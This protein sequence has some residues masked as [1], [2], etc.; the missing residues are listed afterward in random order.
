MSQ[1]APSEVQP[2]HVAPPPTTSPERRWTLIAVLAVVACA[3]V[4]LAVAWTARHP[5]FPFDEVST[6]QMSRMLAGD[7]TP[8][9]R[10]AGYFPGWALVLAPIWWFVSDPETFYRIGAVV[11]VAVSLL[12]IWPLALLGR[13]L[14]LTTAQ[15]VAAAAIVMAM[16]ARAI[17]ADYLLSERLLVLFAV[18]AA[19]AAFR[20]SEQP[21]WRRAPELGLWLSLGLFTHARFLPVLIAAAVWLVLFG[22]RHL[23]VGA[24]GLLVLAIGGF[25]AQA[26]G[27]GL[28]ER[29]LG[30][31]FDQDDPLGEVLEQLTPGL[32]ARTVLGQSWYQVVAT[33]GLIGIGSVV[34]VAL[35]WRE[36]RR[37]E[38]GG[39]VF[40]IGTVA[41]AVLSSMLRW[42]DLGW[43]DDVGWV[44]LDVWV[45]GRY[46]DALTILVTM[47]G[48]AAVLRSAPRWRHL[49][50]IAAT[51]ALLVP[52]IVWLAPRVPTWGFVTPAH[53]PGILPFW[54]TLPD[55]QFD[56]A[57]RLVP[58]LTNDNR[59][60]LIASIFVI[61]MLV[62]YLVLRRF[63]AVIAVGLIVVVS[64]ASLGADPRSD[65]FQAV[66]LPD[67][68]AVD[69]LR[70][71]DE[72]LGGADVVFDDGCSR[73]GSMTAVGQ[74]YLGWYLLPI[75][76]DTAD[77]STGT[78][79]ADV[80]ISC[81][82]WE[83]APALQAERLVG[84]SVWG[85]SM[86]VLP[87]PAQDA[88][89]RDGL[90]Q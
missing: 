85:S 35:V 56:Q 17:Q 46:A 3:V 15:S 8:Y 6:F 14:H 55:T 4:H 31:P 57:Q 82:D 72:D 86:W 87:G 66:E 54:W 58:S 9:V 69:S 53:I 42:A 25:A 78:P 48:L 65:R 16:P 22:L 73:G 39:G 52:V 43:L 81:D 70:Q 34:L 71:L 13:R 90:L 18:L 40:I 11:C 24:L 67:L 21:T 19:L 68:T 59:F 88:A 83:R 64:A 44:R 32:L 27:R 29:L 33:F 79:D 1:V 37:R 74:N 20:L 76:Q 2:E 5:S 51:A 36:L 50:G 60:W 62:A 49:T 38:I 41:A 75:V 45:Y 77:L 10:G 23:R 30:R 89:E 84:P 80:V 47:L 28:N 26:A 63:P 61:G 7:P 12:T